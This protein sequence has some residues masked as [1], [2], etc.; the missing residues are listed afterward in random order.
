MRVLGRILLVDD[1]PSFLQLYRSRL[2]GEGYLV[3]VATTFSEAIEWLERG[4]WDV[5][6]VDQKLSGSDGPDCGLDLVVEVSRLVPQAKTILVTGHATEQA[7]A[8][9]FR[10]GAYDYLEK[11]PIFRVLLLAKLRNAL[12][13][14]RSIHY[15]ELSDGEVELVIRDTW[16]E[17]EAEVD[18]FRKGKLLEDLLVLIFKTIPGFRHA[19]ARRR[20]EEEEID[21]VVRNESA[22]PFW[23]NERTSYILVECKNWTRKAGATE[24]RSFL[25]KLS[26]KYNRSRLG[27]FIAPGGFTGPFKSDLR[28]ERRDDFLVILIG[29]EEL[30]SFVF[31][32]DRNVFLKELHE[33]AVLELQGEPR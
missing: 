16:A 3:E 4:G 1:D 22:D 13:A 5:V 31:A 19:S 7:V 20:N 18:P 11:G 15:G 23:V 24:I 25:W 30:R 10:D 9:A 28:A 29:R 2:L 6:L 17:V 14:V 12:E 26:R 8:R 27:L 21:V 32:T 33:R